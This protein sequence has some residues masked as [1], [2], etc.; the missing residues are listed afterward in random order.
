MRSLRWQPFGVIELP[1]SIELETVFIGRERM[2][3]PSHAINLSYGSDRHGIAWSDLNGD[4]LIDA[5]MIN[6]GAV[7]EM[8][9]A[10][11][12]PVSLAHNN[13]FS[14]SNSVTGFIQSRCPSRQVVLA[15]INHDDAADIYVVCGREQPP[16]DRH[17]NELFLRNGALSFENKAAP[18]GLDLQDLGAA[19]WFDTDGDGKSEML[20]V[21]AHKITIFKKIGEKYVP[22]FEHLH[23][24]KLMQAGIGA[25]DDNSYPDVFLA[26]K[27]GASIVLLNDG[28]TIH[29]K[30]PASLGLPKT[31][32]CAN[33]VDI[34]N[35]G[36]EEIHTLPQGI[37][38]RN[39]NGSFQKTG[40]LAADIGARAPF[41]QW[42][43]ANNDG[44]RDLLVAMKKKGS[45]AARLLEKITTMRERKT[46]RGQERGRVFRPKLYQLDLYTNKMGNMNWL[47]VALKG[48]P[49][50]KEAV[51]ARVEVVANRQSYMRTV[52]HAEGSKTS[53]GH[54]RLYFGLGK[55]DKIDTLTVYWPDGGIS[56]LGSVKVNQ[57]IKIDKSNNKIVEL[58]VK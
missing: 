45:R 41:C 50:N 20:W 4:G 47:S 9:K 42:F 38:T 12:Y 2:N 58:A 5:A 36:V 37:F 43:D 32:L 23:S 48:S 39:A 3:P 6:G 27:K 34:D 30:R 35:D 29:S 17:P 53:A 15:D 44:R 14:A 13:T 16:R 21:T 24:G 49:L 19:K 7:G 1:K 11:A 22:I 25:I 8:R 55:A 46:Y 51:G 28:K 18:L 31:A 33:F 54:Y 56:A 10:R 40:R 57:L 26:Y 52:S